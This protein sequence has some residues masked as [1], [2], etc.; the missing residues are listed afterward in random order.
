MHRFH[1][2]IMH[3]AIGDKSLTCCQIF[4][5]DFM[6]G[7]MKGMKIFRLIIVR[8]VT[9]R[10]LRSCLNLCGKL[11]WVNS[12]LRAIAYAAPLL[13][14][15]LLRRCRCCLLHRHLNSPGIRLFN[16]CSSYIRI[17]LILIYRFIISGECLRNM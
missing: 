11:V 3:D 6:H 15:V 12:N 1:H 17:L 14:A 13:C 10:H 9:K 2:R 5:C 16:F 7:I 8:Q 4:R